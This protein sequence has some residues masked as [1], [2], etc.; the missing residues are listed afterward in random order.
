MP[1]EELVL[2]SS[3]RQLAAASAACNLYAEVVEQLDQRIAAL[4]SR[5]EELAPQAVE[6]IRA[7]RKRIEEAEQSLRKTDS[8]LTQLEL[9]YRSLSRGVTSVWRR[10]GLLLARCFRSK[11]PSF[12]QLRE[13]FAEIGQVLEKVEDRRGYQQQELLRYERDLGLV[14]GPLKRLDAIL[15]SLREQKRMAERRRAE[16][17]QAIRDVIRNAARRLHPPMLL[18]RLATFRNDRSA[19]HRVTD[20]SA[21]DNL[22][23]DLLSLRSVMRRLDVLSTRPAIADDVRTPEITL[24][25][26]RRGI[27][28]GF[29]GQESS[30]NGMIPVSGQGTHHVKRSRMRTETYR[31]SNGETKTRQV[32]EDYWDRTRVKL[33]GELPAH[34][35]V[36]SQLWRAETLADTICDQAG[37]WIE[38]GYLSQRRSTVAHEL[39]RLEREAQSLTERILSQLDR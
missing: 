29:E 32:S 16:S 21:T 28:D 5:Q 27:N 14:E 8:Q 30:G 22:A 9:K 11:A 4:A 35:T 1:P 18:T 2:G 3:A 10:I 39:Q 23:E 12:A 31:G 37:D 33:A 19:A 7:L 20:K 36:T 24:R 15:D 17:Q 6:A 13:R 38:N 34:F 26:I 25:E